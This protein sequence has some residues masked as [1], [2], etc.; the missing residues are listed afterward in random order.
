MN[1]KILRWSL[2]S[3]GLLL[4][5]INYYISPIRLSSKK[6]CFS[7]FKCNTGITI[8]YLIIFLLDILFIIYLNS[9]DKPFE[10]LPN[11]WWLIIPII[12][13]PLI[14]SVYSYSKYYNFTCNKIK[15]E[16]ECLNNQDCT[17][18]L[19]LCSNK[20]IIK[21]NSI[22]SKN[23][24]TII[25]YIIII[26]YLA[27]FFIEYTNNYIPS[28]KPLDNYIYNRFGSITKQPYFASFAWLKII[29]IIIVLYIFKINNDYMPC[30][31][32]LP[33]NW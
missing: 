14:H 27:S 24:R 3:F 26:I 25:N 1:N 18:Q 20:F 11:L 2:I 4:N 15:K 13:L 19:N 12:F 30:K 16:D 32:N 5:L 23:N 17:Y 29:S 21:P 6:K 31:Y 22:F 9:L 28:I 33:S 10:K 7:F 8:L